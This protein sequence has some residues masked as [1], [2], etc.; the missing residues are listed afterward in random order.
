[1]GAWDTGSGN[2]DANPLFAG[3]SDYELQ[4]GSPCIDTGN[5]GVQYDDADGSRNDMGAYGGPN[6]DW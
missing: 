6:G 4:D 2:F 1:L 5:P 3:V